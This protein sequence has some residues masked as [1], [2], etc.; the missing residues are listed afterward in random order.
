MKSTDLFKSFYL[1]ADALLLTSDRDPLPTVILEA[2]SLGIPVIARQVDGVT[3]MIEDKVTG[4][5]W[6]YE[7]SVADVAIY[8]DEIFNKKYDLENIKNNAKNKLD[9]EFSLKWKKNRINSLIE[10]LE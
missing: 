3:E 10:S 6:P 8:I 2:M 7:A 1:H 9:S 5:S 4:F